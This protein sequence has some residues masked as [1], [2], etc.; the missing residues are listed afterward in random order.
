MGKRESKSCSLRRLPLRRVSL[1]PCFLFPL[2]GLAHTQGLLV[3]PGQRLGP[4]C[5]Q[6]LFAHIVQPKASQIPFAPLLHH[7]VGRLLLARHPA[8]EQLARAHGHA[9]EELPDVVG[10]RT[11]LRIEA[12]VPQVQPKEQVVGDGLGGDQAVLHAADERELEH[13]LDVADVR[14]EHPRRVDDKHALVDTARHVLRD[15]AHR[16]RQLA[17]DAR[18]RA[19]P[20]RLRQLHAHAPQRVQ[21]RR[22][23]RVRH[24]NNQRLHARQRLLGRRARLDRLDQLPHQPRAALVREHDL[25][26]PGPLPR[27]R[28]LGEQVLLFFDPPVR[29]RRRAQ[30]RLRVHD[31]A[32]AARERGLQERVRGRQRHPAVAALEDQAD[33]RQHLAH[34]RE[35]A[36]VVAQVVGP[37]DGGRDLEDGAGHEAGGFQGCSHFGGVL[38]WLE[39]CFVSEGSIHPAI[40]SIRANW[41]CAQLSH[42]QLSFSVVWKLL[43]FFFSLTKEKT[44]GRWSRRV[45]K[46]LP[47]LRT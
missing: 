40:E 9:V 24:P 45:Q 46:K 3:F 19:R 34:R 28:E 16:R 18:L 26:R 33:V 41:K 7:P 14:D 30:V 17:R 39:G 35:R 11:Q 10:G 47:T 38:G 5:P 15:H 31:D 36:R 13:G 42:F 2:L 12:R 37:R 22:L 6:A 1:F 8:L 25:R 44:A 4:P 21:Q 29:G 27:G 32:V 20:R 23:P 43:D